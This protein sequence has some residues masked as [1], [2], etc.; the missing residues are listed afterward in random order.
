GAPPIGGRRRR[1]RGSADSV[2]VA[3]LTG[4]IPIVRPDTVDTAET[5]PADTETVDT[6]G[7]VDRDAETETAPETDEAQVEVLEEEAP[8]EVDEVATEE[9]PAEATE[10]DEVTAEAEAIEDEDVDDDYAGAVADY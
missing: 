9:A 3:E 5:A 4:E 1:R 6:N 2:T 7:A 10:V 8:A